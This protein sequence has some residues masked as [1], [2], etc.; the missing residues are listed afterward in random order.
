MITTENDHWHGNRNQ[1]DNHRTEAEGILINF[2]E[3]FWL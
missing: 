3:W 1:Y 2:Y